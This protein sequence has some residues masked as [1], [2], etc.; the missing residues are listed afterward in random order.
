MT[1][2][3]Q[4]PEHPTNHEEAVEDENDITNFLNATNGSSL[5]L[6]VLF[7][8]PVYFQHKGGPRSVS[9]MDVFSVES[10]ERKCGASLK[11]HTVRTGTY[12]YVNTCKLLDYL[13]EE[14]VNRIKSGMLDIRTRYFGDESKIR[15]CKK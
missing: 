7:E 14:S 2:G 6:D 3:D 11:K 12:D 13:P 9:D 5:D 4:N 1:W 10:G 15:Y 8:G